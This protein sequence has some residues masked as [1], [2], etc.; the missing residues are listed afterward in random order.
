MGTTA[1]HLLKCS[2][3]G[4]TGFMAMIDFD[5]APALATAPVIED[6]RATF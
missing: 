1:V 3:L 5:I 2:F 6:N 4:L